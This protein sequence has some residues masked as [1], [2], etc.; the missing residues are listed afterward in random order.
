V[1][2]SGASSSATSLVAWDPAELSRIERALATHVGPMA[3]VMVREAARSHAD[4]DSLATA[5]SRHIQ[6]EGKRRQFMDAARGG[7]HATPVPS[8]M[9]SRATPVAQPAPVAPTAAPLSEDYKAKVLL[10]VTRKMGPIARVM[11]KRAGDASGGSQERFV[12]ILL[13]A[14]PEADRW[15]VQGE[16]NKLG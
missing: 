8:P 7:S 12:Q 1:L 9:S 16:I 4:T 11:V 6:E 5:V 15:A 13:E 10:V 2:A 14:L 3:R